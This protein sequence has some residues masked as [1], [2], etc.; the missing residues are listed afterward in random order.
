[1]QEITSFSGE[2]R[3]VYY[4]FTRSSVILETLSFFNTLDRIRLQILSRDFYHRILP[5]IVYSASLSALTKD[6]LFSYSVDKRSVM[7]TFDVRTL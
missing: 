6:T 4:R 3:T 2:K 5:K 1:M 7:Y